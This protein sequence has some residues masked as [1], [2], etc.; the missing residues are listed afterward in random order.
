MRRSRTTRAR[1]PSRELGFESC[2]GVTGVYGVDGMHG[3]KRGSGLDAAMLDRQRGP[4]RARPRLPCKRRRR[5]AGARS[6]RAAHAAARP[7][8]RNPPQNTG[9]S[10]RKAGPSA[11]SGGGPRGACPGSACSRKARAGARARGARGGGAAAKMPPA[12]PRCT[13]RPALSPRRRRAT[14]G[15][16]PPRSLHH[17]LPRP[18]QAAAGRDVPRVLRGA[19]RVRRGGGARGGAGSFVTCGA[20]AHRGRL[21]ASLVPPQARVAAGGTPTTTPHPRPRPR[22]DARPE[23]LPS[24]R[25]HRGHVAVR[26]ARRRHG[27]PLGQARGRGEGGARARH[28]PAGGAAAA[29]GPT[30]ARP[31]RRAR[32]RPA[33]AAA[34][35][36]RPSCWAEARCSRCRRWCRGPSR[37]CGSQSSR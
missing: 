4:R 21:R 27:A 26:V 32:K 34:A 13:P 30:R 33:R 14:P 24:G 28:G 11:P 5:A 7:R 35:A 9:P 15:P 1:R 29:H 19:R 12:A 17:L 6:S 3:W 10:A 31:A 2:T 22:A 25:H 20:R 36:W 18:H 8:V 23:L 16:P 37:T